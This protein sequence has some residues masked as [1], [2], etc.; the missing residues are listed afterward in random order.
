MPRGKSCTNK[1]FQQRQNREEGHVTAENSAPDLSVAGGWDRRSVYLLTNPFC[2]HPWLGSSEW[3]ETFFSQ[4]LCN[5]HFFLIFSLICI[6]AHSKSSLPGARLEAQPEKCSTQLATPVFPHPRPQS[7]TL[8][9]SS[10]GTF[11]VVIRVVTQFFTHKIK[12][13]RWSYLYQ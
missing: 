9:L 7:Q 11:M 5:S 2:A 8:L 1:P 12:S 10:Y 6:C 13:Q 3:H 4:W